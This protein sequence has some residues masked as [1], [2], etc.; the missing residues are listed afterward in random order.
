[1]SDFRMLSYREQRR[2]TSLLTISA[3]ILPAAA[4]VASSPALAA[5]PLYDQKD[6]TGAI[7]SL[8]GAVG[9]L[10]QKTRTTDSDPAK[11]ST[12]FPVR[13]ALVDESGK[14]LKGA[15]VQVDLFP[16]TATMANRSLSGGAVSDIP[17]AAVVTD[18]EG[19]FT[20]EL[21]ALRSIADYTDEDGLV[22]LL[23]SSV[24][25]GHAMFYNARVV[26]PKDQSERA[27]MPMADIRTIGGDRPVADLIANRELN[28][29]ARQN[30]PQPDPDD[31]G[32][33][34]IPPPDGSFAEPAEEAGIGKQFLDNVLLRAD[35]SP[36]P[37]RLAKDPDPQKLCLES[38][39]IHVWRWDIDSSGTPIPTPIQAVKTM[40]KLKATYKWDDTRTIE[41]TVGFDLKYKNS[42]IK[43][44]FTKST[45]SGLGG[46]AELPHKWTGY[47]RTSVE[48]RWWF[49]KCFKPK[50][51]YA[52]VRQLR[53]YRVLGG[54][55]NFKSSGANKGCAPKIGHP[56]ISPGN[57]ITVSKTATT[58]V[59]GGFNME[60]GL[61][62]DASQVNTASN[63]KTFINKSKKDGF[64]CGSNATI[65]DAA[66][67]REVSK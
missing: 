19:R 9:Q 15:T 61:M 14:P 59:A 27:V 64:V 41:T 52:N 17:L 37:D 62:L 13:G 58:K 33:G 8:D 47:V 51:V 48:Q 11:T 45:Q 34:D 5:E 66:I 16:G 26:L 12:S 18:S 2:W 25:S 23:F 22:E 63:V 28:Q 40:G 7:L 39:G 32:E 3:L 53:P 46:V 50:E 29:A 56:S 43:G 57:S 10:V 60:G 54:A 65:R 20:L 31:D 4:M 55:Q 44:S 49:L 38:V 21:P 24:E 1:M 30:D 35:T 6:K 42:Q 67:V 36:I